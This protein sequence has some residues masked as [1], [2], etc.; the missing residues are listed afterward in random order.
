[1]SGS[2]TFGVEVQLLSGARLATLNVDR[3]WTGWELRVALK[4]H[5]GESQAVQK[6]MFG[7]EPIGKA[8]TL[9]EF[10]LQ[11]GDVVQV[12]VGR[13]DGQ[14]QKDCKY[15][16]I[17]LLAER[18]PPFRDVFVLLRNTETHEYC[19]ARQVDVAGMDRAERNAIVKEMTG[20]KRLRH[21]NIVCLLELLRTKKGCLSMVMEFVDDGNLHEH[22]QRSGGLPFA[23]S[24]VL[25]YLAQIC[26]ALAH[27]H[28]HMMVHGSLVTR[29]VF[30]TH[31][32]QVKVGGIHIPRTFPRL[33]WEE[34][35]LVEMGRGR[36]CP[37]V[38]NASQYS[39][40]SDLWALGVVLFE[41]ASLTPP[42]VADSWERCALLIREARYTMPRRLSGSDIEPLIE[43]LLQVD[44][45][46]RPSPQSLLARP[47]VRVAAI[48]A[49]RKFGLG[50]DMSGVEAPTPLDNSCSLP[51]LPKFSKTSMESTTSVAQ[52]PRIS[53]SLP[54]IR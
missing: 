52:R 38:L 44:P 35:Q 23:T 41:M 11:A 50:I 48:E 40:Q 29:H 13:E 37:E 54:S 9:G 2:G 49:N 7:S 45:F 19:A 15:Q 33:E 47:P 17:R 51:K 12:V 1:M 16:C 34:F 26:V 21:P 18:A 31:E 3:F 28:S 24:R 53:P 8:Q 14:R 42:F 39:S 4:K 30:L 36:I 32:G 10:G 20:W 46:V 6:L 27:M 43:Q 22:L 5:V 25:R